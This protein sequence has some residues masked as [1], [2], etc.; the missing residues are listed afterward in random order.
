M[1]DGKK[2][3]STELFEIIKPYIDKKLDITEIRLYESFKYPDTIGFMKKAKVD[4]NPNRS[5]LIFTDGQNL[6][7]LNFD[8]R[9]YILVYEDTEGQYNYQRV[10]EIESSNNVVFWFNLPKIS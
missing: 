9:N 4:Y 1:S 6:F 2:I 8:T 10:I 3:T 5:G 7:F